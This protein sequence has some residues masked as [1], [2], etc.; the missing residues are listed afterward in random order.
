[1][2]TRY[3]DPRK[4]P[5]GGSYKVP[6]VVEGPKFGDLLD[7]PGGLGSCNTLEGSTPKPCEEKARNIIT[8]RHTAKT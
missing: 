1:M 4:D 6:L 7:P 3:P 2:R 8:Q 5:N